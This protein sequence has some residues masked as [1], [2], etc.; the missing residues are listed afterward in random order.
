[1]LLPKIAWRAARLNSNT[2][3]PE[4]EMSSY[5]KSAYLSLG[6]LSLF[7]LL[8]SEGGMRTVQC[9]VFGRRETVVK[10]IQSRPQLAWRAYV[11]FLD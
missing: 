11:L 1:M 7:S 10:M 6:D 9:L 8:Q 4:T 2:S 3:C 5:P